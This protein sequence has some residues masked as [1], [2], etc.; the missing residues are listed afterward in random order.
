MK[1]K[2]AEQMLSNALQNVVQ[3]I[4]IQSL[5]KHVRAFHGEGTT[6]YTNWP[7]DMD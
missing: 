7:Q 5:T 1:L 3:E 2:M 6:K 4:R